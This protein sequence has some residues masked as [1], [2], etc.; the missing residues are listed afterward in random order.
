MN[1]RK[2]STGK[3][4][5]NL[6]RNLQLDRENSDSEDWLPHYGMSILTRNERIRQD[7]NSRERK[8]KIEAEQDR[9][10]WIQWDRRTTA[11]VADHNYSIQAA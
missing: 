10:T 2:A 9:G 8:R 6:H 7:L 4:T 11:L 3:R 5:G 1:E